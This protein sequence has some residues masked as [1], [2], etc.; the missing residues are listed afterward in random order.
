MLYSRLCSVVGT[1]N[2]AEGYHR[3]LAIIF[4]T[5]RRLPL[6]MFMGKMQELHNEI[7]QRVKQVEQGAVPK[8]TDEVEM[9]SLNVKLSQLNK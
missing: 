7:R 4:D 9:S 8:S 1:T 2:H 6:S 5:R 3:G